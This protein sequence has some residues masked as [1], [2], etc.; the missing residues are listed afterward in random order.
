MSV[1]RTLRWRVVSPRSL[2]LAAVPIGLVVNLLAQPFRAV[3]D[4][5]QTDYV[6][7]ATGARLA[8][9]G[10]CLYC[11]DQQRAVQSD[12][13]GFA[14]QPG[15]NR[16]VH[17]AIDALVLRPVAL[18]AP[19]AGIAVVEAAVL[20][21]LVAGAVLLWSLLPRTLPLRARTGVTALALAS[22]PAAWSV[23][24]GQL[25]AVAFVAL[26]GGTVLLL[27]RRP[28]LAGAVMASALVKPQLVWLVPVALAITGNWRAV[29]GFAAGALS[30]AAGC[31]AVAGSGIRG[32][33]AEIAVQESTTGF[34]AGVG[35][36]ITH[37]SGSTRL[38][39]AAAVVVAAGGTAWLWAR[40]RRLAG[41]VVA[42]VAAGTLLSLLASPHMLQ[43]DLLVAA[44][45][46]AAVAR[47]APRLAIPAAAA[48]SV[49]YA[50]DQV[51]VPGFALI[52]CAV[53]V[54]LLA[55]GSG[56]VDSE[57]M[58]VALERLSRGRRATGAEQGRPIHVLPMPHG[59]GLA[60]PAPDG[61]SVPRRRTS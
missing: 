21:S 11:D 13:L 18:L 40:R 39:V 45:G 10:G 32:W 5:A 48:L 55:V 31:L 54:A 53:L 52:E 3:R 35:G 30:M 25:D 15:F 16:F 46:V 8:A 44:I 59:G 49:A 61:S 19:R 41:D 27:Q 22:L 42:V 14:V 7:Y 20:F 23:A 24:L 6:A 9:Q 57:P 60:S 50:V 12:M 36:L 33:P 37:V 29:A 51:V 56:E 34:G 38:G 47:R 1:S 26:A 58:S 4:V 43:D 28:A 2:A 17:P